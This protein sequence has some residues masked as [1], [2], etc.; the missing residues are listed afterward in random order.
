MKNSSLWGGLHLHD[1][2]LAWFVFG[3]PLWK[4]YCL[5]TLEIWSLVLNLVL[6][7]S[8]SRLTKPWYHRIDYMTCNPFNNYVMFLSRLL[9][10]SCFNQPILL[11]A[12]VLPWC[13]HDVPTPIVISTLFA[14][15]ENTWYFLFSIFNSRIDFL[16]KI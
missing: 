12:W 1:F 13:K 2:S 4:S 5:I 10:V 8:K 6:L 14:H 9:L 7:S 15:W 11:N 3:L 16:W